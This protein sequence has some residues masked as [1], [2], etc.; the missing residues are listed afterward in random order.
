MET[1]SIHFQ[2]GQRN[3]WDKWNFDILDKKSYDVSNKGMYC[4][5][6]GIIFDREHHSINNMGL[7]FLRM[8]LP[9]LNSHQTLFSF[10]F[11]VISETHFGKML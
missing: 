9:C 7:K 5:I 6:L 4:G 10:V 8:G 3:G 2:Q 1:G 11:S